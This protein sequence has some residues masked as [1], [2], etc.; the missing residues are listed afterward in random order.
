[1]SCIPHAF[2]RLVPTSWGRSAEFAP[3]QA[4]S[5]RASSGGP[6]D[7]ARAAYSHS[8][9]V[10]SLYWY[11]PLARFSFAMNRRASFQL[12]LSTGSAGPRK[13]LGLAPMTSVHCAWVISYLPISNPLLILT[14]CAG[15][16][17]S[18]QSASWE[19]QPM[20]NS[21]GSTAMNSI[22][23]SPWAQIPLPIEIA[24]IRTRE[25][26]GPARARFRVMAY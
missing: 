5:S 14:E 12:T 25:L 11:G 2:G 20:R 10:G 7:P 23:C 19:R 16:S 8:A 17:S 15:L 18:P 26:Q 4:M 1:M 21:P 3:C 24:S 9:S 6:E 22:R 13:R